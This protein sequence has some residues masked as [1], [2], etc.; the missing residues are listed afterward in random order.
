MLKF[1]NI[2][3]CYVRKKDHYQSWKV[4]KIQ[5]TLFSL[6]PKYKVFSRFC[7]VFIV[8]SNFSL[9]EKLHLIDLLVKF[10]IYENDSL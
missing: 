2:L 9:V 3:F 5:K 1:Q 10:V 8:P 7:K 6:K 4:S